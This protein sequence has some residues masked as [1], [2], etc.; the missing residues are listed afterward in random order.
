M[1]LQSVV[2]NA[3]NYNSVI[4]GTSNSRSIVS[5]IANFGPTVTGHDLEAFAIEESI[6]QNQEP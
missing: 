3:C 2:N 5:Q 6:G 4:T 1:K